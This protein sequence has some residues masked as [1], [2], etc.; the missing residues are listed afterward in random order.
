MERRPLWPARP[1]PDLTL[2][3]GRRQVELVVHDDDLLG[4]DAVAA[5]ER[6]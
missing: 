4:L 3:H 6:R 1:P 5:R 2:E